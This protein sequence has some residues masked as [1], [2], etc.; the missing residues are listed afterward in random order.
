MSASESRLRWAQVMTW[1]GG[2]RGVTV[3][4]SEEGQSSGVLGAHTTRRRKLTEDEVHFLLSVATVLA[5]AVARKRAEALDH[6][7]RDAVAKNK[8]HFV[9]G[10]ASANGAQK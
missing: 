6:V 5:M 3:A 8:A 9:P 4:I 10:S 7:L 1:Q 2:R